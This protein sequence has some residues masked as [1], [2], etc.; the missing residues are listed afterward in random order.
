MRNTTKFRILAACYLILGISILYFSDNSILHFFAG[1]LV[2]FGVITVI[3]GKIG[4]RYK[5]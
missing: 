4:F 3:S 2:G 1:A 5:S